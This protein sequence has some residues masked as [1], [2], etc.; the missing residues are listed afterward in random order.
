MNA[1]SIVKTGGAMSYLTNKVFSS[2]YMGGLQKELGKYVKQFK[3]LHKISR[4]P[5]IGKPVKKHFL[6]ALGESIGEV[7]RDINFIKNTR[8]G[9]GVGVAGLGGFGLYKGLKN[10]PRRRRP[11]ITIN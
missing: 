7:Q 5:I 4:I 3:K 10:K 11:S 9:I 8:K 6:P 2:K 1:P